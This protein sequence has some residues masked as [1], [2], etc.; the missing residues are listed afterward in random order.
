VAVK[1]I[2]NTDWTVPFDEKATWETGVHRLPVKWTPGVFKD[3]TGGK[4]P[5]IWC[6]TYLPGCKRGPADPALVRIS[7]ASPFEMN[8][9]QNLI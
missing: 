5:L 6:R 4:C 8:F 7:G 2:A 9:A 1:T 3:S